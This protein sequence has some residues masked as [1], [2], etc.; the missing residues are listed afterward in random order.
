MTFK[1]KAR[2]WGND[3]EILGCPDPALAFR[4]P[5]PAATARR[6][7]LGALFL[8]EGSGHWTSTRSL[9]P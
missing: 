3:H 7:L 8:D 5:S 6:S 9:A 2:A 4:Y 1:A